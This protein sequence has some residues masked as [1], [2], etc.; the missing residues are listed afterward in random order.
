MFTSARIAYSVLTMVI[1]LQPNG[2]REQ[3]GK[4]LRARF[5]AFRNRNIL[6]E[7]LI[8]DVPLIHRF[9]FSQPCPVLDRVQANLLVFEP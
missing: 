4:L 8:R 7:F 9:Q 5:E 6:L 2:M 1:V 3:P